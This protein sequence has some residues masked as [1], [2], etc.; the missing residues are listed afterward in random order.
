MLASSH[1]IIGA[2]V[3]R[4][5]GNPFLAAFLGFVTHFL[6]DLVPHWDLGYNFSKTK[7][8]YF[9]VF[10][11]ILIGIIICGFFLWWRPTN[12]NDIA[13]VLL[14]GFFGLV[15][16]FIGFGVKIFKIKSFE[17]Y[18]HHHDRLHW[19]IKEER[20]EFSEFKIIPTTPRMVFFG[21]LWQ[22]L[23]VVFSL[24]ILWV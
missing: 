13:S 7:K 6:A 9:L 23:I 1:F 22:G 14:G 8:S 19:F 18:V 10:L 16:D 3:G 12:W 17:W 15:P 11:D 5:S 2:S 4:L 21:L 24:I 20:P